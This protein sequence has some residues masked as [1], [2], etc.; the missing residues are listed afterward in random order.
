MP[1]PPSS[2]TSQKQKP[3]PLDSRLPPL[4]DPDSVR[5]GFLNPQQLPLVVFAERDRSQVFLQEWVGKNRQWLKEQMLNFGAVMFRGFEIKSPKDFQ[6]VLLSFDPNLGTTYRGTSPRTALE[7]TPYVFNAAEVPVY[8][9]IP[10]HIEMSFLPEVPRKVYFGCVKAPLSGGGATAL[11]DFRKVYDDLDEETRAEFAQGLRYERRNPPK[12]TAWTLDAN[13]MKSW[14]DLFGSSDKDRVAELCEKEGY[15]CMWEKP[16]GSIVETTKGDGKDVSDCFF[17]STWDAPAFQLHPETCTPVWFNHIN[18]FHPTS[19][20]C[21]LWRVFKMTGEVA[22]LLWCAVA[23]LW[24]IFAVV[25]CGHKMGLR[26]FSRAS[27]KEIGWEQF[28]RVRQLIW[29]HTAYNRWEE[30]DVVLIDNLSVAHGRQPT[31]DSGRKIMVSWGETWKRDDWWRPA[32]E[33]AVASAGGQKRQQMK[34]EM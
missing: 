20:P 8:F 17:Y 34:K 31:W 2:R 24:T 7:G 27:G 18:V 32:D 25:V 11:T 4:A 1:V 21:E 14:V 22:F 16:D 23:W 30:G 29:K 6:A 3:Q 12:P 26:T 19:F 10:N 28:G 13:Y 9:P 5:L 15:P 33:R